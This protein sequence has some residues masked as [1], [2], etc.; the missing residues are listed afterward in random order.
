MQPS[1]MAETAGPFL[2]NLRL[3]M[4]VSL[5]L[6]AGLRLTGR[7]QSAIRFIFYSLRAADANTLFYLFI[8]GY[9]VGQQSVRLLECDDLCRDF[10][11]VIFENLAPLERGSVTQFA[12]FSITLHLAYRHAGGPH[13]MEK[14]NP[15][16][17]GFG[18]SAMTVARAPYRLDQ[19][20]AL[21]VAQ[22]VRGHSAPLCHASDGVACVSHNSNVHLDRKS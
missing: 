10:G 5:Y 2:P 3:F 7:N 9:F 20:D 11:L 8:V 16:L 14:M 4:A 18:V 22:S 15:G 13:A 17:V 19:P 12:Q 1:P 6:F 21:I